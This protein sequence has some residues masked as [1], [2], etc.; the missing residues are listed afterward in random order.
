MTKSEAAI[1]L[2]DIV[3]EHPMAMGGFPFI[4]DALDA[5]RNAP[6]A[7]AVEGEVVNV[8]V[9]FVGEV[10]EV[11][12]HIAQVVHDLDATP[13]TRLRIEVIDD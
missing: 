6:P 11:K 13:G 10:N 2:A 7:K 12:P 9:A 4:K 8:F 5:Y 3:V 1:R